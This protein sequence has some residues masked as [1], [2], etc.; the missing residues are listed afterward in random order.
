MRPKR[1]PVV[2]VVLAAVIF[3][4]LAACGA[5]QAPSGTDS[6]PSGTQEIG[7]PQ[8]TEPTPDI[9][10]TVAAAVQSALGEQEAKITAA[11][12]SALEQQAATIASAVQSTL[13][14]QPTAT[15]TTIVGSSP[16]PT[17]LATPSPT[18]MLT[19]TMAAVLS[20]TTSPT[21]TPVPLPTPTATP[22]ATI[23]PPTTAPTPSPTPVPSYFL[24]INGI[25]VG[26]GQ[27]AITIDAGTVFV[28]PPPTGKGSYEQ[29]SLVTLT[30]ST[31]LGVVEWSG[32]VGK[33]TNR[34]AEIRITADTFIR[35]KIR[36]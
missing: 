34:T 9:N 21:S 6:S 22:T 30:V 5:S 13:D 19:P 36:R 1:F 35:V 15:A 11:V 20:S 16:N 29:G 17:P 26:A 10:A 27:S 31:T 33:T 23:T 12:N 8:I 24:W 18:L 7:E 28:S 4:G 14:E 25:Q 32:P 2:F 3:I